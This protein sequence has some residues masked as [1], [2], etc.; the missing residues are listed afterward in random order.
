MK[1][2]IALLYLSALALAAGAATGAPP[3]ADFDT[4]LKRSAAAPASIVA[5]AGNAFITSAD[6]NAT[7]TI[8][9]NGLANWSNPNTVTSVWFRMASAG[10]ATLS[11]DARLAGSTSSRIRV[12]ANGQDFDINLTRGSTRTVNVGTINVAT[13]GYVRVDLR[14]IS[15]SGGY[16]GDVSALRVS[17]ASVLNYANDAANYY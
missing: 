5:L 1:R 9:S 6:A 14:G 7:E 3:A 4:L 16:F 8:T 10:S 12:S 15:K 11:L 2:R 17:T 13:P